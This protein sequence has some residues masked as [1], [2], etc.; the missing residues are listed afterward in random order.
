VKVTSPW[1]EASEATEQTSVAIVGGG[2]VGLALAGLLGQLG[3]RVILL[4]RRHEAASHPRARSINLRTNEIFRGM[5]LLDALRAVSLPEAWT[6]RMIYVETLAGREIGRIETSTQ[7]VVDGR[8]LSPAPWLLSSQDQIEPILRRHAEA[9]PG[10][11]LRFATE[12][13]DFAQDADGVTVHARSSQP[14][15]LRARCD[16][17]SAS[18]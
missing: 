1:T 7:G 3:V 9:L 12:L 15:A 5:G 11:S 6:R 8:R 18:P 4:E 13:V 2:P 14:T 17:S 10:V 16:E